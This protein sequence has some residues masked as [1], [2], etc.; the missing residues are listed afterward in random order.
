MSHDANITP[1]NLSAE[2]AQ[3]GSNE[4]IGLGLNET[5]G[6][7][8][9]LIGSQA[10]GGAQFTGL[11][12]LAFFGMV[13]WKS[14]VGTDIA[15]AVMIPTALFLA[16]FDLLPVSGGIIDGLLI[17]VAAVFAFGLARMAFR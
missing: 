5:A 15:A 12:V 6:N 9:D 11:F 2:L 14:D 16:N 13:L 10:L 1:E 17:A 7:V 3:K 8:G 4:S